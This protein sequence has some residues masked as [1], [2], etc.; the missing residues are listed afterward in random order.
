MI[1]SVVKLPCNLKIITSY[2]ALFNFQS[3]APQGTRQSFNIPLPESLSS[4]VPK[5]SSTFFQTR[6][7]RFFSNRVSHQAQQNHKIAPPKKNASSKYEN[8]AKFTA[9]FEQTLRLITAN[10][11]AE[12]HFGVYIT[13]DADFSRFSGIILD[14]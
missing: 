10:R 13:G 8:F 6:P 3:T 4:P 14:F 9:D 11:R 7:L 12:N 2:I 5:V 1:Y